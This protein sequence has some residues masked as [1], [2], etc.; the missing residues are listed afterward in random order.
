MLGLTCVPQKVYE[1]LYQFKHHFR[2]GQDRHFLIFCW[3]MVGITVDQGKGT[4]KAMHRLLPSKLTYWAMMRMI[5]SGL[6][7]ADMLITDMVEVVLATLPPPRDG[8]LHLIGDTTI[9]TKRGAKH[10]LAH[11]TKMNNYQHYLFGFEMVLLIAAWDSYRIPIGCALID[12]N[13]KGHQNILFR[14]M[15]RKFKPPAWATTIIVEADA[16]FAAKQ[17]FKLIT[18]LNYYY[19]FAISRTRKFED[20]KHV[21]DLVQHLPKHY[22]HRV[23][24][25]KPT[26]RRRDY[27][28]YERRAALKDLGDVTLLLS[29]QRRNDGPKKA[30]LIVTNIPD[31]TTTQILSYY[32]RRWAIEVCQSQPVK[33]T[34]RPLRYAGFIMKYLR[35]RVKREDKINIH[36]LPC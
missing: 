23:A 9:K 31:A 19:V 35:G 2:C 7:D 28:V 29:K 22:Y 27:W 8:V 21:K 1:F 25:Y 11:K 24:S 16:G 20:G 36:I 5:R 30:K 14:K 17:T 15:L 13:R 12:P 18:R 32:A 34:W 3:L 6:W 33:L 4:I 10:P 26:G